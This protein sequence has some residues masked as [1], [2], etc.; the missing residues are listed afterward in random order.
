M[1]KTR[2]LVEAMQVIQH[3]AVV[4]DKVE[5]EVDLVLMVHTEK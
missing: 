4:V 2:M 1:A 5:I 3:A